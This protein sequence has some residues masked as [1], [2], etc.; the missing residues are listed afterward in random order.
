LDSLDSPILHITTSSEKLYVCTATSGVYISSDYG[1]S[2]YSVNRRVLL[3]MK[4]LRG[5][6]FDEMEEKLSSIEKPISFY[7][8]VMQVFS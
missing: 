5:R 6:K 2:Y 7:D 4:L 3:M 1:N 8:D